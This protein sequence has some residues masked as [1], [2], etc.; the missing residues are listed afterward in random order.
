MSTSMT[1]KLMMKTKYS[2]LFSEIYALGEK[3]GKVNLRD[4]GRLAAELIAT[5]ISG[6]LRGEW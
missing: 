4:R 1:T 5:F 2:S 6:I 3:V